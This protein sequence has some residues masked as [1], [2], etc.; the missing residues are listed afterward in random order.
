MR[1]KIVAIRGNL[2][3]EKREYSKAEQCFRESLSIYPDYPPAMVNLG[4]V[5]F[6]LGQREE[7]RKI[8]IQ[9]LAKY[10]Q[11]DVAKKYLGLIESSN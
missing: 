6:H 2:Y 9:V 8:I 1:A 7:A 5:L 11:Q 3:I 4:V 10:P